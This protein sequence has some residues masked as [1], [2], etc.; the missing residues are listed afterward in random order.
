M[1]H[2]EGSDNKWLAVDRVA[3]VGSVAEKTHPGFDDDLRGGSRGGT[4]LL[5]KAWDLISLVS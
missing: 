2:V 1:Q 4:K 3:D 5:E